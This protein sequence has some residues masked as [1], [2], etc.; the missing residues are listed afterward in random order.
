MWECQ[1]LPLDIPIPTHQS[2]TQDIRLQGARDFWEV[3]RCTD[4]VISGAEVLSRGEDGV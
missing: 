4:G 2:L 1:R 3:V